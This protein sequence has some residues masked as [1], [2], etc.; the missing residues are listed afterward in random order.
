MRIKRWGE[1]VKKVSISLLCN[2]MGVVAM[3][4]SATGL[5]LPRL[6]E[7]LGL[8]SIQQGSLVSIQFIGFAIAILI[9]GT[10]SD[11]FGTLKILAIAFLGLAVSTFMFG[12]SFEFWMTI[13]GV[14]FI[15]AFGS[16]VE[17]GITALTTSYDSKRVEENN[18]FTQVFFTVGAIITPLLV[19]F[20]MMKFNRWRYAYYVVAALCIII[21][22]ITTKYRNEEQKKAGSMKE[23]FLQYKRVFKKPT[24]LIAP[25]ALFLYVGAEIGLWGFA[26]MFFEKQGYGKIS[27]ILSSVLIWICM[28]VGRALA[29]QLLKKFSMCKIMLAFGILGIVSLSL[30][31]FSNYST[32]VLWISL[33]GFAC[34]PFYPMIIAWMTNIT[35]E[36]SSSILAFTMAMGGLGP[37]AMGWIIGLIVDS[38]G[39]RYIT[40]APACSFVLLVILI[41]IFRNK[42]VEITA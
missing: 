19:L 31:M 42:K 15:G 38:F 28:F 29:V 12:A 37:V 16:V 26:P 40:L 32:A 39:S 10:F 3:I 17:N 27:G 41:F 7:E 25:I 5:A 24:Y 8:T 23:A 34:A 18:V 2:Q 4:L 36:K 30:V 33:S 20:F 21:A 35:G 13:V 9:G 6:A 1:N 14:F 11:R 22:F